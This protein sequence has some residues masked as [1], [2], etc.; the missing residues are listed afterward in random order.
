[1]MDHLVSTYED[2][3]ARV[4]REPERRALFKQHVNTDEASSTAE[5]LTERGQPKIAEW[6]KEVTARE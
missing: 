1:M 2:E 4:V 6:P 3:W 5:R